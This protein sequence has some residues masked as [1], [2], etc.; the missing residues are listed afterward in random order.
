M[1]PK[2]LQIWM[3]HASIT[4]TYDVYGRLLEGSDAEEVAR[5]DALH[6]KSALA[7]LS[8][9]GAAKESNLPSVGLPRPAGFEDRMG[10]QTPA[11]PRRRLGPGRR[12][13]EAERSQYPRSQR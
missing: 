4:V 6:K 5:V 11:A 1:K 9:D 8:C 13:T 12:L 3:G 2:R 7:G 10:H